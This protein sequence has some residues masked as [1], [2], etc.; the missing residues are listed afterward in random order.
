MKESAPPEHAEP[1]DP[2]GA[3][4]RRSARIVL[5]AIVAGGLLRLYPDHQRYWHLELQ[6]HYPRNAIV[7][8]AR[9]D[10]R[11]FVANNGVALF[12]AL[13]AVFTGWYATARAAGVYRDR[14]DLV[15]AYAA[16]PFP[17]V[18][19]SRLLIAAVSTLAIW[20]VATLSG[21]IFGPLAAAAAAAFAATSYIEVRTAHSVWPDAPAAAAAVAAVL[22]AYRAMERPG[23]TRSAV[24]AALAGLA[25]A[26]RVNTLPVVLP[27]ALAVWWGAA[28]RATAFRRLLV[29]ALS[30]GAVLVVL[31][32]DAWLAPLDTVRSL[33]L[34]SVKTYTAPSAAMSFATLVPIAFGAL[35]SLLAA[36]GAG[37]ALRRDP[38]PA[39]L[40]GVFPLTQA[41]MLAPASVLR[42]RY[43]VTLAPFVAV[44]AGHGA[45]IVGR[46]LCRTR[47]VL[48]LGA[49]TVVALAGP[50]TQSVLY[51]R[52]LAR[53]DTRV[54]AAH[55]MTAHVP[56]GTK[57]TLPNLVRYPNPL[58]PL[59][60]DRLA[61][62]FP[63]W[64]SALRA[65]GLGDPRRTYPASYL[66]F[67]D[68]PTPRW[69]PRDPVVVTARH[70]VILSGM[71]PPDEVEQKLR[72]AGATVSTSFI[73]VREPLDDCLLYDPV[74]A[75]YV[76][77]RCLG[78]VERPGPNITVWTVPDA[79]PRPAE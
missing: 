66:G 16:D 73:G 27:V 2:M 3:R 32:P 46:W 26:C 10:W 19:A 57:V 38:R 41:A 24:A 76:P 31:C 5:L 56:A 15:A 59:D 69:E 17:F 22:A 18:V 77:L 39:V 50:A 36:I 67:F 54:L 12:D 25:V 42:A 37:D 7:A 74:D 75:D 52:L 29:A 20:I 9:R 35:V 13:R 28:S 58:L 79:A 6:E 60:S 1:G 47:S 72:A 34:E 63:E 44:F 23:Y 30:A 33:R 11:P 40:V 70:P 65:R 61:R 68:S 21:S 14:V 64:A 8:V 62:E 51:D 45:V 71:N 49:V 48:G 78:A 53:V 55:W 43:L 4:A